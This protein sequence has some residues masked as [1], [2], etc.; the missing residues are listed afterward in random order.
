M[1]GLSDHCL[2]APD[3]KFMDI[4][5]DLG[6]LTHVIGFRCHVTLGWQQQC[7]RPSFLRSALT[8]LLH[9]AWV[10]ECYVVQH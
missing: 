9:G 1:V 5:R 2:Y 8:L 6:D 4:H 10:H 3:C 7:T